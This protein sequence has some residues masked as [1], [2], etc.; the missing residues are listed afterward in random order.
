MI[1]IQ[2]W[3]QR[4]TQ[5]ELLIEILHNQNHIMATQADALSAIANLST[6]VDAV[7]A[8]VAALV[9]AAGGT[10]TDEQPVLDALAPVLEK[11]KALAVPSIPAP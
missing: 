11:V 10:P 3:N 1:R 9:A 6:E 5:R 7:P 2:L 4:S 8:R